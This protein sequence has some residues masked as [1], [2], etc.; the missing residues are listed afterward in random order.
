MGPRC[1]FAIGIDG[2]DYAECSL[3]CQNGGTCQK[4]VKNLRDTYGD[5]AEDVA[6]MLGEGHV[7]YEHCV[8]PPGFF[9]IRC[10]YEMEE[11]SEDQ[12]VCFHGSTCMT[13]GAQVS[14][15]CESSE[16]LTAGLY[17]EFFATEVCNPEGG[18][19][20]ATHRGFCTNGGTC[21]QGVTG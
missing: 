21:Y 19:S 15:N 17:C 13:E 16:Q 10:E 8:C 3:A 4:G 1:A 5:L 6:H 18:S 7:D 2:G 9:G 14:C 20:D 12:H 11:C